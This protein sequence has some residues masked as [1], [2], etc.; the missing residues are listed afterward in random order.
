MSSNT[1]KKPS[2]KSMKKFGL[3]MFPQLQQMRECETLVFSENPITSF[4]GLC[5]ST[6]LRYLY[7][8][9]TKI[10]SFDGVPDLPN[11]E[12]LSL[13]NTP[14]GRYKKVMLMSVIVFEALRQLD[15]VEVPA[16]VRAQAEEMRD[17]VV[18]YLR[19]GWVITGVKPIRL[20]NTMTRARLTLALSPDRRKVASEE[21]V[22]EQ[23]DLVA[24]P[25][26]RGLR[27]LAEWQAL[28]R[29]AMTRQSMQPRNKE[30]RRQ[31]R[32]TAPP[33]GLRTMLRRDGGACDP[34]RCTKCVTPNSSKGK[35][36]FEDLV[37]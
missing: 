5:N 29:Q 17:L 3:T 27:F 19:E 21:S 12:F 15:G 36:E 30:A 18:P 31:K 10:Q 6:N 7:L 2:I 4:A 9:D 25:R 14:V 23:S 16:K 20:V 8:D 35:P 13:K 1:R 32:Q 33:S 24:H 22:E 28:T 11:L 37:K 26:A 34:F